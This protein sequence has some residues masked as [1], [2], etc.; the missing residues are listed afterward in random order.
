MG[1]HMHQGQNGEMLCERPGY[2][3]VE[4]G[5]YIIGA[6]VGLVMLLVL[7]SLQLAQR[8]AAAELS[9]RVA[10]ENMNYCEKWGLATGTTANL[11]C[12]RDL[13][14]IREETERR[15]EDDNHSGF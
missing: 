9:R 13:I 15:T 12:I 6:V 14:R 4:Q 5:L 3:V 8:D 2:R 1:K 10:S 11:D 7:P